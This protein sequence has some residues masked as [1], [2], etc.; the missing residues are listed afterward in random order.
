MHGHRRVVG[1]W[2]GRGRKSHLEWKVACNMPAPPHTVHSTYHTISHNHILPDDII[3]IGSNLCMYTYA[4]LWT[5]WPWRAHCRA[6]YT[7]QHLHGPPCWKCRAFHNLTVRLYYFA[8]HPPCVWAMD[9]HFC[10]CTLWLLWHVIIWHAC[11]VFKGWSGGRGG[12]KKE[13]KERKL[14]KV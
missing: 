9:I 14:E 10:L 3:K 5:Y 13:I 8:P 12:E 7:A 1:G 6:P 11:W 2:G 4:P